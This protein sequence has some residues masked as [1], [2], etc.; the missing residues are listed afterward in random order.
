LSAYLAGSDLSGA[1]AR[2]VVDGLR[3]QNHGADLV[4]TGPFVPRKWRRSSLPIVL[5]KQPV[6]WR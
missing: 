4:G 5:E 3:R 6:L 2:E 1:V